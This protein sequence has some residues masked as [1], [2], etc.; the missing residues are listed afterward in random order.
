MATTKEEQEAA[1]KVEAGAKAKA[2]AEAKEKE[3]LEA[4]AKKPKTAEELQAELE[5]TALA[6]KEA[7]KEAADRRK[8]LNAYEEAEK[9]RLEAEMTE[10]EKTAAKLRAQETEIATLKHQQI[11]RKVA[12]EIGLP[13][14]L[15]E[16][17]RG[18][19]EEELKADAEKLKE[20]IPTKEPEKDDKTKNLKLKNSV[21]NPA[22]GHLDETP[23]QIRERLHPKGSGIFDPVK[24]RE[25][26]G[27][28]AHISDQE[29][30]PS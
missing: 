17:L 7:N 24:V 23:Q 21:T 29:V 26:G 6:L 3:R 30:K 18:D 10:A 14:V 15:A 13:P 25:M 9:K 11:I 2:D 19:T 4:D 5:K 8:K 27:G 28:L 16:R 1:A 22:N 20:L 12:D